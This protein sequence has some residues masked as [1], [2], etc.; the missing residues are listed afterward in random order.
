M[1]LFCQIIIAPFK[2]ILPSDVF[3][4]AII[5][6]SKTDAGGSPCLS[7]TLSEWQSDAHNTNSCGPLVVQYNDQECL[8]YIR[9][10]T[11]IWSCVFM[12]SNKGKQYSFDVLWNYGEIIVCLFN[13]TYKCQ[14]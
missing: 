14:C 8:G 1:F 6:F 10:S 3:C 12:Q 5:I 13:I 9:S 2:H 11:V 7:I 4:Y